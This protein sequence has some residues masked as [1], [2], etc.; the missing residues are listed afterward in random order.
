MRRAI[1]LLTMLLLVAEPAL[2]RDAAREEL[3]AGSGEV[4]VGDVTLGY[5][6]ERE[7]QALPAKVLRAGDAG[8]F[9]AFVV[10]PANGTYDVSLAV[11]V[12]APVRLVGGD[13]WRTG[14]LPPSNVSAR[15]WSFEV[16]I[17]GSLEARGAF[18]LDVSVY[19]RA[20][21]AANASDANA[22]GTGA[23]EP[24]V[25]SARFAVPFALAPPPSAFPLARAVVAVGVVGLLAAGATLW[26]RSRRPRMVARSRALR[27]ET[28]RTEEA[29]GALVE[30]ER[31]RQE[32][33]GRSIVDAKRADIERSIEHARGRLV[34]GEITQHMFD[35]IVARKRE[36]LRAL[37]AEGG[38]AGGNGPGGGRS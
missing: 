12:S 11:A 26:A 19:R 4:R 20:D 13:M 25:G 24:Q 32:E 7:G 21:D 35:Q 9:A 36:A 22:S 33:R 23:W 14:A 30:D 29:Q 27:E 17:E 28:A 10:T 18:L 37:D 38:R 1:I 34:R 15:S 5:V 31:R 8:R 16:P 2:T 6:V 3:D